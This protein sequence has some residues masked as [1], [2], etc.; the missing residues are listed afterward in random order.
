GERNK[1]GLR[2]RLNRPSL[3]NGLVKVEATSPRIA[4]IF[5]STSGFPILISC[6]NMSDEN[7]AGI[8]TDEVERAAVALRFKVTNHQRTVGVAA[9]QPRQR[10]GMDDNVRWTLVVYE[11]LDND[12]FSNLDTLMLQLAPQSCLI[13]LGPEAAKGRPRGD[14]AKVINLMER[15]DVEVVDVKASLFRSDDIVRQMQTLLGE[16]ASLAQHSL[17]IDMPLGATCLGCLFTHLHLAG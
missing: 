14:M 9:R 6:E 3:T 10:N 12:Q 1:S 7:G 15:Q 4:R 17:G 11:F 16:E 13:T 5:L 2:Y 8:R